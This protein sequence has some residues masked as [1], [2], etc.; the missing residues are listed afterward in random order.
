MKVFIGMPAY[1]EEL[2][3][4]PAIR[5]TY[6]YADKIFVVNGSKEGPSTDRTA[7]E[8]ASVGPKVKIVSGTFVADDNS[9]GEQKQRQKCI[10]LMERGKDNWCIFQDAD[11]VFD[12]LQIQRLLEHLAQAPPNVMLFAYNTIHFYRDPWHVVKGGDW[13]KPRRYQAFRLVPRAQMLSYNEIGTKVGDVCRNWDLSG[14]PPRHVVD[15]VFYYHYGHILTFE[16]MEFK[17]KHFVEQ[18]LCIDWGY[19][20]HEWEKFRKERFIPDWNKSLGK[21]KGVRPYDGEHPDEVK[22]I[23]EKL[24]NLYKRYGE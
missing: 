19:E 9:W 4:A 10:N 13:N 14:D 15:D 17:V 2:I 8:A 18:G 16:R 7:E 11:E 24:A 1:N 3:I 5:S 23:L 6:D 22:P 20:P 21:V 12:D